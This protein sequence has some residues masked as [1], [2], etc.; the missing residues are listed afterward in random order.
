MS[1]CLSV[2]PY[3]RC[4]VYRCLSLHETH[5]KVPTHL[6]QNLAT[7][8]QAFTLL[9]VLDVTLL[10]ALVVTLLV[11]LIVT[12]LVVCIVCAAKR[13]IAAGRQFGS[14]C[15]TSSC[16]LCRGVMAGF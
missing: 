12:L 6:C 10:V 13:Q 7:S 14:N 3:L 16:V 11:V 9:V 1:V 4:L 15:A 8:L 2:C 5:R